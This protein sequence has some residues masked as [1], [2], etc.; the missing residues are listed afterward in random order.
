MLLEMEPKVSPPPLPPEVARSGA[1]RDRTLE[2]LVDLAEAL[3][4]A[5][6]IPEVLAQAKAVLAEAQETRQQLHKALWDAWTPPVA[7]ES[8]VDKDEDEELLRHGGAEAE[9]AAQRLEKEQE[10]LQGW[11]RWL[12]A[13]QGAAMGLTVLCAAVLALDSVRAALGVTKDAQLLLALGSVAVVCEV[14]AWGLGTSRRHLA[15]AAAQQRDTAQR[16]RD[17]AR[18]VVAARAAAEATRATAAAIGAAMGRLEMAM[19]A[20]KRLVAAVAEDRKVTPW[21]TVAQGF[22]ESA[23]VLEDIVVALG[24]SRDREDKEVMRKLKVA[25]GV[26]VA[27]V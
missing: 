22:P 12:R 23:R 1:V 16:L 19:D 7:T 8:S 6:T 2:A 15:T 24:T 26:L 17:R 4:T 14:A 20:L 13:G 5:A 21:G 10:R 9:R 3:G 25:L 18:Q 27:Q 11:Q